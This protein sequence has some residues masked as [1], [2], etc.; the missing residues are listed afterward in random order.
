[1]KKFLLLLVF[2]TS[3]SFG[4]EPQKPSNKQDANVVKMYEKGDEEIILLKVGNIMFLVPANNIQ[5]FINKSTGLKGFSIYRAGSDEFEKLVSQSGVKDVPIASSMVVA[6][7]ENT[8]LPDDYAK[9]FK[10]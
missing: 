5:A 4:Q 9:Y 6:I 3:L 2:V 10:K 8:V 7:D 1:M